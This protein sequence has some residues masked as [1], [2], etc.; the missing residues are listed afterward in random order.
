MSHLTPERRFRF[1]IGCIGRRINLVD[2]P[3]ASG[4]LNPFRI[5]ALLSASAV[6]TS[7]IG[8]SKIYP[9]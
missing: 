5:I 1:G 7:V 4:S 3:P 2:G 9:T 6:R 8:S